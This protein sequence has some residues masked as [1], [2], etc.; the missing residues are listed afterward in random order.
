MRRDQRRKK[1]FLATKKQESTILNDE[2]ESLGT[3][4]FKESKDEM[5]LNEIG[6]TKSPDAERVE[7]NLFKIVGQFK[8]PNL[9]HGKLWNPRGILKQCGTS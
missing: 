7:G 5:K 1:G 2:S 9:S 8:N 6:D 4:S 3:A